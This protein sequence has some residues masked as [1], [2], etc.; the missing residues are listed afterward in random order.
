MP[1]TKPEWE[2]LPEFIAIARKIKGKYAKF[3]ELD[4]DMIGAYVCI[5]KDLPPKKDLCYEIQ[6]SKEPLAF[7]NN[8]SWGVLV[9]RDDWDER[10]DAAKA[11]LVHSAMMQMNPEE[12]GKL[13][14][15]DYKDQK[16]MVAAFGPFWS[17]KRDGLAN[18]LEVDIERTIEENLP[19]EELTEDGE[20]KQ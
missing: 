3:D 16:E 20:T 18:L 2:E 14:S 17:K 4:V 13:F 15:C 9:W 7:T 1:Q 12:P 11:A 19:P 10:D 5:N 8:K 6:T